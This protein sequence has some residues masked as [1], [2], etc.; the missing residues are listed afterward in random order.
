MFLSKTCQES[1]VLTKVASW[2]N[3]YEATTACFSR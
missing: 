1:F 2:V 3:L